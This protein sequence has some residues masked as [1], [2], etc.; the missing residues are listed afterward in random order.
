M[1]SIIFV[2]IILIDSFVFLLYGHF[3]HLHEVNMQSFFSWLKSFV[4]T[5]EKS[6]RGGAPRPVALN[7]EYH[8]FL[9]HSNKTGGHRGLLG[10]SKLGFH[11]SSLDSLKTERRF[12]RMKQLW[13]S[14]LEEHGEIVK[15][16]CVLVYAEATEV[17]RELACIQLPLPWKDGAGHPGLIFVYVVEIPRR[18]GLHEAL[19]AFLHSRGSWALIAST[20]DMGEEELKEFCL[21]WAW[22]VEQICSEFS[23]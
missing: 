5:S 6:E 14:V 18:A 16:N 1:N 21:E 19:Q 23:E 9:I 17:F 13:S 4:S 2:F 20:R 15:T 11:F 8:W 22:R 7:P 3:L 12:A 10:T